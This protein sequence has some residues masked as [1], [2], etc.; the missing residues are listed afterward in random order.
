[1]NIRLWVGKMDVESKNINNI[2]HNFNIREFMTIF[3]L[4]ILLEDLQ[5]QR[6]LGWLFS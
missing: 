5:Y 6:L 4:S 3:F 2:A 1:M